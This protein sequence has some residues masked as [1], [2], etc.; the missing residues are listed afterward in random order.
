[1]SDKYRDE[2]LRERGWRLNIEPE[3]FQR[4]SAEVIW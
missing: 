3:V 4:F 2:G 1:M